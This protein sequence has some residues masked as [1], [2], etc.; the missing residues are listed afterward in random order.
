M[1]CNVDI[2]TSLSV[3]SQAIN[4]SESC[5]RRVKGGKR[6]SREFSV[7]CCQGIHHFLCTHVLFIGGV[8]SSTVVIEREKKRYFSLFRRRQRSTP[9]MES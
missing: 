7:G 3:F 5:C 1:S 4:R 8:L 9:L 2:F 6:W